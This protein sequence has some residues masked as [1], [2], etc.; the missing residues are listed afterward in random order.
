MLRIQRA[1]QR[2]A[3]WIQV[4]LGLFLAASI[5]LLVLH[6]RGASLPHVQI[7]DVHKF[8]IGVVELILMT[9]LLR[10]YWA[11]G[12][13]SLGKATYLFVFLFVNCFFAHPFL[14][15]YLSDAWSGVPRIEMIRP[16]LMSSYWALLAV[17]VVVA[18]LARHDLSAFR[19]WLYGLVDE[20][21]LQE[22]QA[23]EARSLHFGR[24]FPRLVEVPVLGRLVAAL[25]REGWGYVVA[26]FMLMLAGLTLR[27][28]GLDALLLNSD[29]TFHLVAAKDIAQGEPLGQIAYR[30]SLFTV[31][32]PIALGLKMFGMSLWS[33]RLVGVVFSVLA[34]V[35]FYLLLRRINKAIGLLSAG[36]YV[37]NP[38]LIATSQM[39]REYAY[40]AFYFYAI[41]WLMVKLHDSIPTSFVLSRDYR[42]LLSMRVLFYAGV[43]G[44]AAFYMVLIDPLST[45]KVV[46]ASYLVFGL[47]TLRKI[48]WRHPSNILIG[49]FSLI[50]LGAGLSHLKLLEG[51]SYALSIRPFNGYFLSLF[52]GNPIQQWYSNRS[53][54]P[55]VLLILALVLGSYSDRRKLA[56]PFLVLTYLVFQA[57]FAFFV[58][59]GNKPRYGVS[60]QFWHVAVMAVGLFAAYL[61]LKVFLR[62]SWVAWIGVVLAFWVIPQPLAP[63]LQVECGYSPITRE[64]HANPDPTYTYLESFSS[65]KDVIV[66]TG[67]FDRYL[68]WKGGLAF[69]RVIYYEYDQPKPERVIYEAV[70]TYPRGWIVLDYQRGYEWSR[71]LLL[72]DSSYAGKRVAFEGWIGDQLVYRWTD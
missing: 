37:T 5:L 40:Y 7:T 20:K 52:Y 42:K 46:L 27:L 9:T 54:I 22:E 3:I 4:A 58:V 47:L 2:T 44:F 50:L 10:L 66:T 33:A 23:A 1:F 29:E 12:W 34:V 18:V 38:W 31:T 36:L 21:R 16:Y 49:V 63:C 57:A 43:L 67:F 51:N 72:M 45:M 13:K 39:A 41:A 24:R 28:W 48:D 56:L 62:R 32:L 59:K 55:V 8:I 11:D 71:P 15:Y 69:D 53:V 25:H 70:E 61:I 35:P 30:R 60:I 65:P 64:Y 6:V 17:T 68:Q 26:V 14:A 19:T